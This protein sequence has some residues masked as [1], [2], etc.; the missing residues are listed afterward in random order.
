MDPGLGS[1]LS[2]IQWLRY[3]SDMLSGMKV[4]GDTSHS[5][6]SP[7]SEI[8]MGLKLSSTGTQAIRVYPNTSRPC[9]SQIYRV[10]SYLF[11]FTLMQTIET[12]PTAT[13]E[14]IEVRNKIAN[15]A[16]YLDSLKEKRDIIQSSLIQTMKSNNLKSWKTNDK[17]IFSRIKTRYTHSGWR[18]S[19]QGYQVS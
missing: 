5:K 4:N 9:K 14:L 19:H 17:F 12:L 1:L 7:H 18:L 13:L 6:N 10:Y 3:F 11:T 8:D 2:L 15:V 16:E